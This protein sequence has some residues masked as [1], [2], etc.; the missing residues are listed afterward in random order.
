MN[1]APKEDWFDVVN[2]R[3]EVTGRALRQEIHAK[4]WLHRAVHLLVFGPDGRVLLQRRSPTKDRHPNVWDSSASGHVDSGEDYLVAAKRELHEELGIEAPNDPEELFRLPAS[5]LTDQEFIRI[6]R[7][8]HPGPFSPC[9]AEI[10]EVAW[11]EPTFVDAW[12]TDRPKEFATG[13]TTLWK[14][15]RHLPPK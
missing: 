12:V 11:F 4:G 7:L 2:E 13:F 9:P 8:S 1:A 10:S 14:Q 6:Y 5:N 15:W 3:D